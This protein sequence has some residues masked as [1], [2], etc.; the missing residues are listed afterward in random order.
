MIVQVT[1]R[2]NQN[3]S[4]LENQYTWLVGLGSVDAGWDVCCLTGFG[5]TRAAISNDFPWLLCVDG[6]F[7]VLISFIFKFCG[8][9]TFSVLVVGDGLRFNI[10]G[11][12]G[13]GGGDGRMTGGS[14]FTRS[15]I[16]GI[17]VTRVA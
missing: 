9:G 10:F 5:I 4:I 16:R 7:E 1:K 12:G 8:W 13:G 6:W 2:I 11:G 17:G 14:C 3:E 15:A